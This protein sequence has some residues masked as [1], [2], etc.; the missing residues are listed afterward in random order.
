VLL[1]I[2]IN[3][4]YISLYILLKLFKE[5]KGKDKR[6]IRHIT[7]KDLN[8]ILNIKRLILL[9]FNVFKIRDVFK[10]LYTFKLDFKPGS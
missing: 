10:V 9:L 5:Y 7:L 4:T 2:L 8:S 1:I 6:D 3:K